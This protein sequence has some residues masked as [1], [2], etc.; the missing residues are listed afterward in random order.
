MAKQFTDE[1]K[2]LIDLHLC[3]GRSILSITQDDG[4]GKSTLA[5][6]LVQAKKYNGLIK[7]V[8]TPLEL[9]NQELKKCLKK[10]ELENEILKQAA[11]ILEKK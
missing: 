3:G 4:L 5:K 2:Q 6:W 10:V 11:L 9:E 1:F 8:L 7:P